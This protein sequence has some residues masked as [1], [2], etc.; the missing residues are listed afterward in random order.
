MN[1][2]IRTKINDMA[3]LA[4]EMQDNP[5]PEVLHANCAA[6]RWLTIPIRE[7]AKRALDLQRASEGDLVL[8]D[9]A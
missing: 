3:R 7:E 9:C 1:S 6:I 2:F 8:I 5:S 4:R